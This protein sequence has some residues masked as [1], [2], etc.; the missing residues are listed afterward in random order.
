MP[1]RIQEMAYSKKCNYKDSL[2]GCI[3]N[4]LVSKQVVVHYNL[5]EY[6]NL[7]LCEGCAKV[8]VEDAPKNGFSPYIFESEGYGNG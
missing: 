2:R 7:Y 8:V 3:G 4:G 6:D 5:R 1:T